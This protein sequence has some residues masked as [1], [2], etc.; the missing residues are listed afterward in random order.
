MAL[1]VATSSTPVP[2]A[3]ASDDNDNRHSTASEDDGEER[4]L[5]GQVIELYSDREPPEMVVA[6]LGGDITARVLKTDE[7]AIWGVQVGDYVHL[8]GE[9]DGGVFNANSLDVTER[10]GAADNDGGD[11]D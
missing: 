11:D 5:E 1:P 4:N 8:Q 2:V 9:Y 3:L 6:Q 10:F 7:I